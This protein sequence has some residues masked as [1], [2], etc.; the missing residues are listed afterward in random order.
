MD[1]TT[2]LTPLELGWQLYIT[3]HCIMITTYVILR[4]MGRASLRGLIRVTTTNK[5]STRVKLTAHPTYYLSHN[6]AYKVRLFYCG[7]HC[8]SESVL[9]CIV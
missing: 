9:Y 5:T 2:R 3:A 6:V 8:M 7:L 4:G 1:N